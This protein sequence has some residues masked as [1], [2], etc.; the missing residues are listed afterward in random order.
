M[1]K[2]VMEW[3]HSHR[4]GANP[5][6]KFVLMFLA[7]DADKTGRGTT[8]RRRLA[9]DTNLPDREIIDHLIDLEK[10]KLIQADLDERGRID[11]QLNLKKKGARTK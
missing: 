3:W 11:Y 9:R 2:K 10:L 4:V 6:A 5:Y 7:M 8:S 1:N